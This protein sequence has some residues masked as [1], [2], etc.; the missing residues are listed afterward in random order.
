MQSK[1]ILGL[2]LTSNFGKSEIFY[3]S[4]GRSE[5]RGKWKN[6]LYWNAKSTI[7]SPVSDKKLD[8]KRFDWYTKSTIGFLVGDDT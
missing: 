4:V 5:T 8:W 2:R 6:N 7:R 1:I 3:V